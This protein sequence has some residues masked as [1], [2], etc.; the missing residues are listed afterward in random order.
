MLNG[1]AQLK[2]EVMLEREREGSSLNR[3]FLSLT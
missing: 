2:R 3:N 1:I